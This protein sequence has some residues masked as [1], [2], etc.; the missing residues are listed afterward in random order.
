MVSEGIEFY[1]QPTQLIFDSC[2]NPNH[3]QPMLMH[4]IASLANLPTFV[5]IKN[6]RLE[7]PIR[8][9][10]PIIFGLTDGEPTKF[11]GTKAD[12]ALAKPVFRRSIIRWS[13]FRQ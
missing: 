2:S 8:S 4:M 10:R 5:P 13:V 12:R 1:L 7:F 11:T 3:I 6:W 9:N